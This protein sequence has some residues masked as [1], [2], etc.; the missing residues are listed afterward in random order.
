MKAYLLCKYAGSARR[1]RK[2]GLILS[3]CGESA[4]SSQVQ[5]CLYNKN[6][7]NKRGRYHEQL[8]AQL[9]WQ[10]SLKSS[11]LLFGFH[12]AYK[13]DRQDSLPAE[14]PYFPFEAT[15]SER[16]NCWDLSNQPLEGKEEA[17]LNLPQLSSSPPN[18]HPHN[19]NTHATLLWSPPVSLV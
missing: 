1:E 14:E 13:Q 15:L 8:G 16:H 5:L 3:L 19:T 18:Y 4:S 9:S 12:C 6:R 10:P 17:E 11:W 7:P 2:Q